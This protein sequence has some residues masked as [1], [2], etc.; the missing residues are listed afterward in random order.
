MKYHIDT[1][2]LWDAIKHDGECPLCILE[3]HIE[4][5]EA[6][7]LLG[8][9]VMDPDT[10]IKV[11]EKGFCKK[12]QKLLMEGSNRLGVALMMQSHSEHIESKIYKAIENAKQL[13]AQKKPLRFKKNSDINLG[14]NEE[15]ENL[16]K[17][18]ESCLLC[19]RVAE[20]VQRYAENFIAL[21]QKDSGFKEAF[22]KSK[23]LCVEHIA[24]LL[25]L[26]SSKLSAAEA[27]EFIATI[28]ST[29]KSSLERQKAELDTFCRK[30]DYR[31]KDLPWGNSKDA[32][33]RMVNR[34][35]GWC[36]GAEPHPADRNKERKF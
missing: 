24:Q 30:F 20:H 34:L 6:D 35:Q 25:S 14:V 17:L 13:I 2:P 11:N 26:A 19:D 36:V 7:K 32:P 5:E 15:S 29:L 9:S 16:K 21:W 27:E 22:A 8:A 10:R 23:G 33:E 28:E 1:I 18:S 31:N 12:H 3:R 4:L